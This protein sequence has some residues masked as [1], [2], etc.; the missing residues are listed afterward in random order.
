MP[1]DSEILRRHQRGR[2]FQLAP[3]S[4]WRATLRI[5]ANVLVTGS[6]DALAAFLD[7]ARSEMREPIRTAAATLPATLD[8]VRTLVVTDVDALDQADQQRLR[9]WLDE[10]RTEDVQVVSMTSAPLYSLVEANV[11]DTALYYRLNTI[12]LEIHAV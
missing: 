1:T 4:D 10:R 2:L 9:R 11:F 5:G 3:P 6:D 7:A 8:G 12:L